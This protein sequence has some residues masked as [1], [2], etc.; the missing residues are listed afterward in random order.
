MTTG[1]DPAVNARTEIV[2]DGKRKLTLK[3]LCLF[4]LKFGYFATKSV[5]FL[6]KN[7]LNLSKI[8]QISRRQPA[9]GFLFFIFFPPTKEEN[10]CRDLSTIEYTAHGLGVV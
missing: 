6:L 1:N 4:I 10:L 2:P 3:L 5:D 8:T 9:G 7:L